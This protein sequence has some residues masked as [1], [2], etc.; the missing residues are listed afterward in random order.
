MRKSLGKLLLHHTEI[1]VF[2]VYELLGPI[3]FHSIS[4][5]Y[6]FYFQVIMVCVEFSFFNVENIPYIN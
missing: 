2:S 3:I 6:Y 1:S 5:L 4:S